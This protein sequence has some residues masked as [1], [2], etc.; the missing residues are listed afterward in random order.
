[1][2]VLRSLLFNVFFFLSTF[3]LA[4]WGLI[5]RLFAPHRALGLVMAWGRTEVWGAR[6]VGGMRLVLAGAEHIPPGAAL[7]ASQHQSTF[8]TL[9]WFALLPRCSY[10]A[11][12]E[13]TRIPLFG[14]LIRPSGTIVVDRSAGAAA[15]RSMLRDARVAVADRRQ[16]VMFPEGT[17]AEPGSILP[18][19]P[20]IAAL[21]AA[22]GLPVIPVLTDSG[23]LWGR[24]AFLKRPGTISITV[25]PPLPKAL[26]REVLI[27]TLERLFREGI[28]VDGSVDPAP[29]GL[30]PDRSQTP[31]RN[32]QSG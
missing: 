11:K 30:S 21:A 15:I 25:L 24:R 8:D 32:E 5:L 16:I 2:I 23:R 13:L 26:P 22:T 6:V 1:M 14:P 3:A 20:G 29:A 4:F 27:A 12:I 31:Q 17:R 18:I 10:V 7:I 9:V 28:P 19:Q